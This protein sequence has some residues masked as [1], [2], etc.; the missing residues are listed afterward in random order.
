MS[1]YPQRDSNPRYRRERPA[2]E[3]TRRWGRSTGEYRWPVADIR[4]AHWDDFEAVFALLDARSRAAFGIS[5]QDR[6]FLRQRW[7][8]PGGGR[9]VAVDGDQIVGYAVLDENQEFS[10]ASFDPAVVDALIAHVE[11][12]AGE[13]AFDR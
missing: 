12:A 1:L 2:S 11:G 6:K 9:W 8:L 13:R 3:A 5:A 10:L 4:D 7:E